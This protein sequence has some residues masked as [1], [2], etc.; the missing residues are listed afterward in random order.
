MDAIDLHSRAWA[1]MI[2]DEE[3]GQPLI[4]I[5]GLA[6]CENES[7]VLAGASEKLAKLRADATDMIPSCIVRIDAFWK[8]RRRSRATTELRGHKPGR[9]D[10][11]PCGSGLKYKRCCGGN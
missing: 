5:L 2:E 1:K 4:P 6:G 10:P 8:A 9:Y 7:P 11:S 3:D